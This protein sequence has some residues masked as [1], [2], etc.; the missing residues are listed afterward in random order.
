M[1]LLL[2]LVVEGKSADVVARAREQGLLLVGAGPEVVRLIPP[3]NV[4][5]E[6]LDQG[7][8]ML[9]VALG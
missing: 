8:E 2:G 9:E 4:S 1:G 5:F 7:L 6:E 3:L